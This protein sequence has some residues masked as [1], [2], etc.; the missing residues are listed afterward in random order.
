M[1]TQFSQDLEML[2]TCKI[3]AENFYVKQPELS[4]YNPF[5]TMD[6]VNTLKRRIE[7]AFNYYLGLETNRQTAQAQNK[8]NHIQAQALRAVAFLK[9]RIEVIYALD[10]KRK[11]EVLEKLG[12]KLYLA[13]IQDRDTLKLLDLLSNIRDN[14]TGNI[15]DDLVRNESDN[16]FIERISQYATKLQRANQSQT[17]LLATRKAIAEEA[18][19]IYNELLLEVLEICK[20]ASE[21]YK[22]QP[23]K[24]KLFDY[25]RIVQQHFMS[26]EKMQ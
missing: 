21:F 2:M 10:P 12:F 1:A 5:W 23:D 13:A 3:I 22:N 9:T 25:S 18:K 7:R 4:N 11:E 19:E 20:G 26:T 15:K 6:F 14:L 8:L 16:T 17:S 24:V